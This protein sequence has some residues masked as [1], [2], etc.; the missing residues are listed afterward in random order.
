MQKL[1][2]IKFKSKASFSS[3]QRGPLTV[4]KKKKCVPLAFKTLKNS[5]TVTFR[6]VFFNVCL[7]QSKASISCY[8]AQQLSHNLQCDQME[9]GYN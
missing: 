3:E 6:K 8:D 9:L 1:V 4:K 5:Y 7:V 2:Y